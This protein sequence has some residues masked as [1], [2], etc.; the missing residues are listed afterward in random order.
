MKSGSRPLTRRQ[1]MYLSGMAGAGL[2]VAACVPATAP[3]AGQ[4]APAMPMAREYVIK[5][6]IIQDPQGVDPNNPLTPPNKTMGTMYHDGLYRLT[7]NGIEPNLATAPARGRE[8]RAQVDDP[9]A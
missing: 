9:T 2:V 6:P 3:Q 4:D 1:F 8:R 5:H 7:R